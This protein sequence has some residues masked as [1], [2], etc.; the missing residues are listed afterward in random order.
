MLVTWV[1]V[2]RECK[3][4]VV[5]TAAVRRSGRKDNRGRG[6][7]DSRGNQEP[8]SRRQCRRAERQLIKVSSSSP[9]FLVT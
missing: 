4:S 6:T 7:D 8:I 5:I 2:G 1:D 3:S 9:Y